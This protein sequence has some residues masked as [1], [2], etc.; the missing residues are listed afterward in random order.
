MT[1]TWKGLKDQSV[2]RKPRGMV[3]GQR[4]SVCP[5]HKAGV[6]FVN[7]WR[8][9]IMP[10]AELPSSHRQKKIFPAKKR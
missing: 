3:A 10:L 4:M 9:C 2:K 1:K 5:V 7:I 6:P 8:K